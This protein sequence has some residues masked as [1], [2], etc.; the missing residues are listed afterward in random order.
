MAE[1]LDH[2][3]L[4]DSHSKTSFRAPLSRLVEWHHSVLKSESFLSSQVL[5]FSCQLYP[6]GPPLPILQSRLLRLTCS[7]SPFFLLF[8]S[9]RTY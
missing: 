3:P 1:G 9:P 7:L 8:A 4:L 6:D 5:R 2:L